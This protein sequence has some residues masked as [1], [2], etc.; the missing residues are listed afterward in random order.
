MVF[1]SP[2]PPPPVFLALNPPLLL[3]IPNLLNT[4]P[5]CELLWILLGTLIVHFTS[6]VLAHSVIWCYFF[7]RGIILLFQ[8]FSIFWCHCGNKNRN[9]TYLIKCDLFRTQILCSKLTALLSTG[10][11][12]MSRQER[13]CPW[14]GSWREP[15]WE[16][17]LNGP[18]HKCRRKDGPSRYQGDVI[19]S[20]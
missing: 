12:G 9:F 7:L 17:R 8:Y 19:F 15:V 6:P 4:L 20:F 5:R 11:A 13:F 2:P 10:P 1:R 16:I 18:N 3:V 14:L